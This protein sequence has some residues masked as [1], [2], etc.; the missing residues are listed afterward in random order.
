MII[1]FY[2]IKLKRVRVKKGRMERESGVCVGE[3]RVGV[4]Y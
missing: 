1:L 2:K 3:V 4:K